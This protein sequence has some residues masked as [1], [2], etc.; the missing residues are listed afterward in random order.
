MNDQDE[1]HQIQDE[2]PHDHYSCIPNLVDDMHLTP[3]AFR[4]YCHF[5]RV[6]GELG[7]CWQSGATLSKA[8]NMSTGSISE[9]K[10]ELERTNPPLIHIQRKKKANGDWYHEI[11]VTDI[12]KVNHASF[13]QC[14][15]Q[16]SQYENRPSLGETKNIPIKN[17][18]E[19]KHT[20]AKPDFVNLTVTQAA[21]LPEIRLYRET[22][23]SIP[24]QGQ[25]ETV[26]QAV[27]DMRSEGK[28]VTAD[29]LR[30][31]FLAWA[32]K[33][34]KSNNLD[35]LTE[36]AK[37]GKIPENGKH[38]SGSKYPPRLRSGAEQMREI[39]AEEALK[40]GNPS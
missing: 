4:L 23:G 1:L 3:L 31:F 38:S 27:R 22:T 9:A 25:W 16:V 8:C 2:A 28:P 36:W 10:H 33:G 35:W 29:R 13:S 24:G 6:A 11:T 40:N 20:H 7:A 5:K 30:P 15:T 14:E 26:W 37:S 32:A 21:S 34:F 18:Q 19:I 39:I 12:W 17:N